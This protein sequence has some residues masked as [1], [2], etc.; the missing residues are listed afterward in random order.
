MKKICEQSKIVNDSKCISINKIPTHIK[1]LDEILHGGI[2]QGRTTIVNGGPGCGKSILCMEWLY[3]NAMNGQPGIFVSFEEHPADIRQNALTMGWNLAALEKQNMIFL[4]DACPKSNMIVSGEFNLN[5]LL[6]ILE[7]KALQMKANFIVLDALDVLLRLYEDQFL[8]QNDIYNIH[9]FLSSKN[10]TSV[11]T[12]KTYQNASLSN[13]YSFVDFMA[14]CVIHLDQRMHDQISTRRLRISK[15]RGSGF[16]RNEYPFTIYEKGCAIIP[17]STKGLHHKALGEVISSGNDQLDN[18][19]GGGF[20]RVSSILI[21]GLTGA[22]KTT[23]ASTFVQNVCSKKE[24]VLYV[25][26][27]ESEGAV[28]NNMLSPG[29][30]LESAIKN[31]YLRFLTSLPE[32][33]GVEDHLFRAIRNIEDF[34]PQHLIIDAVSACKRM[35]TERSALD[36]I[37]RLINICKENQITTVLLNQS[38]SGDQLYQISG[39]EISS[40][41]DTAIVLSFKESKGEVNRTMLVLK[42]RGLSHSNQYREF[43]ITNNGI[44]FSD[45]YLGEGG[46][47][48]GAERLEKISSDEQDKR[49]REFKIESM[50][51]EIINKEA[52]L[53]ACRTEQQSAIDFARSELNSLL[54]EEE[55]IQSGQNERKNWRGHNI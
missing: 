37:I 45:V 24:K 36:Y 54:F 31:K 22:G 40:L 8:E 43:V 25:G 52:A 2:P 48:T 27:E 9:H 46:V 11:M 1:G 17:I 20:R 53:F 50:R 47:L 29:I 5:G 19:L 4:L 26:F 38:L 49:R 44:Q 23:L 35:G 55:T 28:V 10:F 13:T 42:S 32:A 30:D 7:G 39:M 16:G 34:R 51:K 41:I 33:M 12:I 15:Y 14:D 6:T 3:H 18:L 21:S